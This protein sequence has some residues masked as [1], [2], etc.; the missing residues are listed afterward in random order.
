MTTRVQ[1]ATFDMESYEAAEAP[2]PD[3]TGFKDDGLEV[4]PF[5]VDVRDRLVAIR[6]FA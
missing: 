2:E 4:C 5:R 6:L 1:L 3:G